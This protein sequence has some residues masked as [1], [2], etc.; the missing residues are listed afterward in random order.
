MAPLGR[1]LENLPTEVNTLI[2]LRLA[3]PEDVF[4]LIRA[5]PIHYITF[6][7]QKLQ[8]LTN[9]AQRGFGPENL[10]YAVHVCQGAWVFKKGRLCD[11]GMCI[12]RKAVNILQPLPWVPKFR[13]T[14]VRVRWTWCLLSS[15]CRLWRLLD[16]LILDFTAESMAYCRSLS[17]PPYPERLKTDRRLLTIEYTR[18]QRAFLSYENLTHR[19]IYARTV[20]SFSRESFQRHFLEYICSLD[21]TCQAE[22]LTVY[23]YLIRRM[24]RVLKAVHEYMVSQYLQ[25]VEKRN[26]LTTVTKIESVR[27]H[28]FCRRSN[29]SS[30]RLA[31]SLPSAGLPFCRRLANIPV[32][33][34]AALVRFDHDLNDN[35]D[36]GL[37]GFFCF[38]YL[39]EP[40][41]QS[42]SEGV[43][44]SGNYSSEVL[45]Q[46]QMYLLR[47]TGCV[48]WE[49]SSAFGES[50]HNVPYADKYDGP[51]YCYRFLCRMAKNH[52]DKFVSRLWDS[53][54][55]VKLKVPEVREFNQSIYY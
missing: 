11:C 32:K 25:K 47:Q 34:Q 4:S 19:I 38:H 37:D 39:E 13:C 6:R 8:I 20:P 1:H 49:K 48:F 41:F 21:T 35:V 50:F 5:S 51:R 55:P 33:E 2:L 12:P 18:V 23:D 40:K 45:I 42:K 26:R 28:D 15:L 52:S 24:V 44:V 29:L 53:A 16:Y 43:F 36:I 46:C 14:M 10:L 31:T 54:V 7:E 22:L 17:S 27:A 3:N 30:S 9:A